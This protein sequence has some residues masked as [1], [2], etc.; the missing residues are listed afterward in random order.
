MGT[1][2]RDAAELYLR[3]RKG[4]GSPGGDGL[5][6]NTFPARALN[7]TLGLG[8]A[9]PDSASA[10]TAIATGFRTGSG[11]IGM[12]AEA[13]KPLE[14]IAETAR[15][16][17]RKVGIISTVFLTDATPAAFYAHVPSRKQLH[18]IALQLVDSG[19]EYFAGGRIAKSDKN[20]ADG[21]GVLERARN[22]GYSVAVG[23]GEFEALKPGTGKIIAMSSLVD[24]HGAMYFT[25]DQAGTGG[26]ITLAEY[27]AKGIELLDNPN[28]FF[29]M[30][31]AGKI[32]W[33]CHANDPGAA[34]H[35]V[36]ALDE[37]VAKAVDFYKK[38]PDETLIVVTG[39]HETGGMS[40]GFSEAGY[41]M[42]WESIQNQRMSFLE[43][44]RKLQEYRAGRNA[45]DANFEDLLALIKE[46]SGFNSPR[47]ERGAL[48]EA[49]H[50]STEGQSGDRTGGREP[51]SRDGMA[52]QET[53]LRLLAE[54]FGG[55]F[56][57]E[58]ER[59]GGNNAYMVYGTSEPLAAITI[60]ILN[61]RAG[62]GWTSYSHTVEPVP[63]SA[64]GAGAALFNGSFDQTGIHDR[65]MKS[66]GFNR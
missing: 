25:L 60:G 3:L 38:H 23:R 31:E 42:F 7:T 12:D 22:N 5:V 9:M 37:A 62:I 58:Q 21:S 2:Q 61:K 20:P 24:A 50:S 4:L 41:P 45:A 33:A 66:A 18:E 51:E 56:V 30:A 27:L 15:K 49:V 43:L 55:S 63:T 26:H 54:A 57:N 39:D 14:S 32:D 65:I 46:A 29:I 13:K 59:P 53:E 64:L 35:D 16:N 8:G 19:F 48:L 34:I 10:G 28:G 11:V 6:M 52:L 47:V 36:L 17:N 40:L 1:G 44:T